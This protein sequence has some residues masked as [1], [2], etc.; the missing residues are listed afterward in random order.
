M[1]LLQILQYPHALLRKQAQ[2]VVRF[3]A[4]L[5]TLAKDMCETMQ[6]YHGIG[7]A[8]VQVGRLVSLVVMDA[9]FEL[10]ADTDADPAA[11]GGRKMMRVV[12][13][14][15]DE[16]SRKPNPRFFVNPQLLDLR[17]RVLTEEGCLSIPEF[18][19]PVSRAERLRVCYQ[20][21]DGIVQEEELKGL[22]AICMQH[23]QDHLEGRLFIDYLPLMQ[24][25]MVTKRLRR[26]S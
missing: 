12:H 7:L 6:E 14:Q 15:E 8:A 24:R 23:E 16:A 2:P 1:A 21:L 5:R 4:A 18:T 9:R 20:T 26:T 17:G 25:Q 19:A 10:C 11:T 13:P 22:E 3:D